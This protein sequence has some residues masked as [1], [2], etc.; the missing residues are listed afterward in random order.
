MGGG[1][2]ETR[3]EYEI[4]ER[5]DVQLEIYNIL[6]QKVRTLVN[7]VQSAGAY[8]ATWDGRDRQGKPAASGIYVYRLK[9][10]EFV[11]VK[12]LVLNR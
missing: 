12:K 3:I 11:V 8:H 10:G 6:G 2:P 5:S 7:G 1:N 4:A 9:A